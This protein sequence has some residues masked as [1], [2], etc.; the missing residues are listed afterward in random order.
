[1]AHSLGITTIANIYFVFTVC[2]ALCFIQSYEGRYGY[3]PCL[4]SLNQ[5]IQGHTANKWQNL[6]FNPVGP[7][8]DPSSYLF[9]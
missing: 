5:R 6:D 7:V 2:W 4:A 1:M 9:H 3:Y 8:L